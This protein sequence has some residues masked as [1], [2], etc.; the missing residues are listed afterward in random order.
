MAK[1]IKL[2]QSTLNVVECN[3]SWNQCVQ[4]I[5]FFFRFMGVNLETQSTVPER[6]VTW[7]TA[8]SLFWLI[9]HSVYWIEGIRILREDLLKLSDY[10]SNDGTSSQTFK[11]SV[12]IDHL[13]FFFGSFGSHLILLF[14]VKRRWLN[15]CKAFERPVSH[16]DTVALWKLRLLAF[17]S[18]ILV[19]TEVSSY[20]IVK[21]CFR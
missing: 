19:I 15:L 21:Q 4:P 17:F 16:L 3:R 13:N 20:T 6:H 18:V 8:V 7:M 12:V 5:V 2:N 14:V 11:W 10:Y 9:F 1:R